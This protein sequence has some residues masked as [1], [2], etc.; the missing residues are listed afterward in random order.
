HAHRFDVSRAAEQF[1]ELGLARSVRQIPDVKPSTH[2]FSLV[3]PPVFGGG[4]IHD[5]AVRADGGCS[6][7]RQK[8]GGGNESEMRLDRLSARAKQAGL[9]TRRAVVYQR[10]AGTSKSAAKKGSIF[11]EFQMQIADSRL[12]C[13]IN[14]Q[15]SLQC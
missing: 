4:P 7:A 14:L 8:R 6:S 2:T 15:S 5:A 13:Q 3:R 10:W 1:L 9:T 12:E 11:V